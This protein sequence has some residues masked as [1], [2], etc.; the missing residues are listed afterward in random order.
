SRRGWIEDFHA[1]RFPIHSPRRTRIP[2]EVLTYLEIE[3]P[4][5]MRLLDDCDEILPGIRAWWVGVH[6][7]SSM[8]FEVDT[9]GG[10]VVI[11]DAAF[12]YG[13]VETMHPL[14]ILESMEECHLAYQ[15]FQDADIFIPLYDPAV[16]ERY[17]GG[18]VVRERVS[19]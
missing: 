8:A 19:G 2:D 4:D 10:S 18:R 11:S 7:R 6:H 9:S 1:P 15:R 3:R 16:M 13:N 17:P 14:G 12:H 5:K